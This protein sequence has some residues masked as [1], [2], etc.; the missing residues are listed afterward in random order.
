MGAFQSQMKNYR[1]HSRAVLHCGSQFTF[2]PQLPHFMSIINH[3]HPHGCLA[4]IPSWFD[5][6]RSRIPISH[7]LIVFSFCPSLGLPLCSS[8]ER[9]HLCLVVPSC[10][11]GV[12]KNSRLIYPPPHP[13]SPSFS[14]GL[15]EGQEFRVVCLPRIEQKTSDGQLWGAFVGSGVPGLDRGIYRCSWMLTKFCDPEV[16][17]KF[18]PA[19]LIPMLQN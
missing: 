14:S 7:N 13:L 8:L 5:L 15:S 4:F 3:P 18:T 16:L 1:I 10:S 12:Q 17:E 9:L 11:V 6:Y 2:W 19:S